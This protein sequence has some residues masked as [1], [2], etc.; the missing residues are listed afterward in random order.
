MWNALGIQISLSK[1]PNSFFPEPDPMAVQSFSCPSHGLS[2]RNVTLLLALMLLL[3]P[4]LSL[5]L[6]LI[7]WAQIFVVTTIFIQPRLFSAKLLQNIPRLM[8]WGW[9]KLFFRTAALSQTQGSR[10]R[11]CKF[12]GLNYMP[13]VG[14]TQ[15]SHHLEDKITLGTP[16]CSWGVHRTCCKGRERSQGQKAQEHKR[17]ISWEKEKPCHSICDHS[18]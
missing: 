11:T 8:L 9:T 4:T 18:Q 1:A 16:H 15:Q 5:V 2:T 12:R 7:I 14:K 10:Q 13:R 6:P 17:M 3:P